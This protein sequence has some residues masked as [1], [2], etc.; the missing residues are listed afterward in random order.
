MRPVYCITMVTSALRD[1]QVHV[2]YKKFAHGRESVVEWRATT[3]SPCCFNDWCN[4][5]SRRF[6]HAVVTLIGVLK[7]G[8]GCRAPPERR[9]GAHLP[10]S[11]RWARRWINHK[12][13]D[14]WPGRRQS[15]RPTV[16]FPAAERHRPWPVP[17]YTAWWQRHM[18]V[19]NLPRVVT[20]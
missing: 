11:G 5:G 16:T 6:S 9:R 18:G 13:C 10:V 20:W 4:N 8:K 3:C 15:A 12:V 1:Q 17:N 19:N 7:K 14:A 2:W